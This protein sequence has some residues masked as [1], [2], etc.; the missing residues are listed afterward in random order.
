M[1]RTKISIA[2]HNALYKEMREAIADLNLARANFAKV[3]EFIVVDNCPVCKGIGEVEGSGDPAFSQ[4]DPVIRDCHE[5]N[6]T[7]YED[8][9]RKREKE[10]ELGI[11]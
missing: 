6:G 8:E 10:R 3:Q 9:K 5:C 2:Q 7:G 4:G 11:Y 1:A